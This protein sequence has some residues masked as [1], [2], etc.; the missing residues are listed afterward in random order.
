MDELQWTLLAVWPIGDL[1][2][3]SLFVGALRV[4]ACKVAYSDEDLAEIA[5]RCRQN[6]PAR[7]RA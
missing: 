4:A 7:A 3:L 6:S 5:E 2:E 1:Y